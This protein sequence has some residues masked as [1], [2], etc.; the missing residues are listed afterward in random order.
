M[1]SRNP[2]T[3]SVLDLLRLYKKSERAIQK[4]ARLIIANW[5]HLNKKLPELVRKHAVMR[6]VTELG[7]TYEAQTKN[8]TK[9]S[10]NF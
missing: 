8:G 9:F 6:I 1:T 7:P 3:Q 4:V 5:G 2:R 10:S